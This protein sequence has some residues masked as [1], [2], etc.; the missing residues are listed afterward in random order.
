MKYQFRFK[1]RIHEQI[2]R[3]VNGVFTSLYDHPVVRIRLSH[4]GYLPEIMTAKQ[5]LERNTRLL[6]M[7]LAEEPDDVPSLGFLGRELYFSGRLEESVQMLSRCEELA[8]TCPDYARLPEVRVHLVRALL[9]LGLAQEAVA[10]AIRSV[11][12]NPEY[13]NAWFE[14]ARA[15]SSYALTLLRRARDGFT[16]AKEVSPSY[17]GL[18]NFDKEIPTWKYKVGLANVSIGMGDLAQACD[19]YQQALEIF[20]QNGGIQS[21]IEKIEEQARYVLDRRIKINSEAK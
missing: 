11:Q 2:G 15:Q 8:P 20:P 7:Q 16:V 14:L 5:K 4:N 18:V 9:N 3:D 13:P 1:G 10:V 6:R 12:A 19:L 21:Q 17:S